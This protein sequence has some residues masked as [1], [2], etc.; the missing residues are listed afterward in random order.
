MSLISPEGLQGAFNVGV[1]IINALEYNHHYQMTCCGEPQLG[2]R[3]LYP[4]TSQKGEVDA[5]LAL[6]DFIAYAD[7]VN[8]LIEISNTIGVPV[9]AL[10]P[11]VIKL[12][13][14]NLLRT[15]R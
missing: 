10:I 5:V 11:H 9:D 2:K 15:I 3:G 1:K 12:Q 8:D 6:I 7:G 14:H 13:E 4:T